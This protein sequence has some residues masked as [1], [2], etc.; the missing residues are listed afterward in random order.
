MKSERAW[1]GIT[2]GF[3]LFIVV[4]LLLLLHMKG[5]FRATGNP[6][7]GLLYF[8]C[9]VRPPAASPGR[10]VIQPLVGAILATPVC[11]LI[12]R[13]F[14]AAQRTFWQQ[15]AWLFSA[16]FWCALGA[17]CFLFIC[18]GWI[19]DAIIRQRNE[20]AQANR[21]RFSFAQASKS[22]QPPICFDRQN[23]RNGLNRFAYGLSGRSC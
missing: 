17:L 7:V 14:F 20:S 21:P 12:M 5:V 11:L 22:V 19:P 10:R 4:C 13:I 8:C 15:L 9:P 18:A 1:V 6:E 2:C 3:F 16:V 23:L